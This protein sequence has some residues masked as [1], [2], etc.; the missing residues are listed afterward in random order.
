M[1][2]FTPHARQRI[3]DRRLSISD[4]VLAVEEPE[5]TY[6]SE[7][8]GREVRVRN[9]GFQRIAAVVKPTASGFLVITAFDQ[10]ANS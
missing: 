3:A 2:S 10:T 7:R 6:P 9:C 4:V 8:P 5:T 1:V